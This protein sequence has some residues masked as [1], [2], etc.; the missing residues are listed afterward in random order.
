VVPIFKERPAFG[1]ALNKR[2]SN[3]TRRMKILI[4]ITVFVAIGLLCWIASRIFADAMQKYE[5][6]YVEKT[7]R[8]LSGMFIFMDPKR[9]FYLNLLIMIISLLVAVCLTRSLVIIAATGLFSFFLPKFWIH[10]Q[11]KQRLTKFELQLVDTLVMMSSAMRSGMSVLQAIELVEKEQDPPTSQEFGLVIREYKVGVHLEEALE[12]MAARAEL[13]D[14]NILVISM[15]IV[16][17]AG[18]NLTEML[19]TLAE[20]MRQRKKLDGK[21][22][23]MTAQGK[24]Q[25]L[26]VTLLPTAIG[27][28]MYVMD[29]TMMMRMF[30]TTLGMVLLGIMVSLQLLGFV[31][32]RKITTLEY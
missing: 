21:I 22:K 20:L 16:L 32:I 26:V 14:L 27:I 18:G 23:S 24:L 31:L 28:M 30:T 6:T 12:H 13:D 9:L 8:T 1:S 19:D 15:N 2:N 7:S 25:A 4:D 29:K 5:Q 11:K 10:W 17:N 3:G